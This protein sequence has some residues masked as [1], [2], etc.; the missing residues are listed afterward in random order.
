[1]P[2]TINDL[3]FYE[4]G[5]S[6][7]FCRSQPRMS[8]GKEGAQCSTSIQPEN[9]KKEVKP[10]SSTA[11]GADTEDKNNNGT[12]NDIEY[13]SASLSTVDSLDQLKRAKSSSPTVRSAGEEEAGMPE[14][15]CNYCST[16]HWY[17]GANQTPCPVPRQSYNARRKARKRA[18]KPDTVG[19]PGPAKSC[20]ACGQRHWVAGK[21]ATPCSTL[22]G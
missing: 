17:A 15:P 22:S 5:Q 2:N 7:A 10:S 4:G 13:R 6:K 19:R 20:R 12:T 21:D 1:M 9:S 8:Q 3:E 11:V 16:Y 18:S 14:H